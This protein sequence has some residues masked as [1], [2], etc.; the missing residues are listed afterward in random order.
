MEKKIQDN[1]YSYKF[2]SQI[3][4]IKIYLPDF[5]FRKDEKNKGVY[6]TFIGR[7]L[8]CQKLRNWLTSDTKT[9][10]YLVTGYRG[11]G[12]TSV[13]NRVID[14]ITRAP[15]RNTEKAFYV[16]II[17]L[18][19]SFLFLFEFT[20]NHFDVWFFSFTSLLISFC[21]LLF[22]LYKKEVNRIIF[23]Q[24]IKKY[25]KRYLY[26]SKEIISKLRIKDK[27]DRQ[28][29]RLKI[30]INLG[31][32][33]LNE[34]DILCLIAC[35]IRDEYKDFVKIKQSTPLVSY[36]SLFIVCVISWLA[37][38][39]FVDIFSSL[40]RSL[41]DI[42]QIY[43]E[44]TESELSFF[45]YLM[46]VINNWMLS[47]YNKGWGS[48]F[49]SI[50]AFTMTFVIINAFRLFLY[51]H[52]IFFSKPF[53]IINRLDGLYERISASVN[54]DNNQRGWSNGI[55]NIS[56]FRHRN[57][58]YPIAN[59]REIE[60]ELID[61]IRIIN[62]NGP[63][64]S[65]THFIIVFD[66]LDK[67]DTDNKDEKDSKKDDDDN[68]MEFK[69]AVSGFP[70]GMASR[71]RRQNVLKLLAN[72][73]LFIS[74][75]QAKFVFISGREL[76]DASLADLSDREFAISSI[77]N[78]II[79]V[80]SFLSPERGET[81]I[82]SMTEQYI[83]KMLLPADYLKDKIYN[84]APDD[85]ALKE[86]IPS[87]RW[88]FEYLVKIHITENQDINKNEKNMLNDIEHTLL[89]LHYFSV[90]LSQISNGSPKK[91]A[92]FFEKYVKTEFDTLRPE[93]WDDEIVF[94]KPLENDANKRQCVLF[95]D[96]NS[97]KKINFI[98]HISAPIMSTIINNASHYGDKLLVSASFMIDHIYKH[99]NGGFSWR[100]LEQ[101]PEFFDTGKTPELRDFMN[102]IMEFLLQ[103][104]IT[105]IL[106]GLYQF[107]FQKSIAEEISYISKVSDEASAIF[108]FTLDESLSM[109]E[110][111]TKLLNHHLGLVSKW[112]G[113]KNVYH[114]VI[115]RIYSNLADLYLM[116][117][118]YYYAIINYRNA[119]KNLEEDS[120]DTVANLLTK[121]RYTLKL[122]LSYEY[123]RT[124]DSAYVTYNRLVNKLINIRFIKE[125]DLGLD[126]IDKR[127]YDWRNKIPMLIDTGARSKCRD[128]LS[129]NNNLEKKYKNQFNIGIWNKEKDI[130]PAEYSLDFDELISG[131]SR[132]LTP[133]KSDMILKLSFFEEV[134]VI[135]QVILAK[136]FVLEKMDLT[137]I[138]QTSINIAESEFRFLH[139]SVNVKEKF[140]ISADFFRKMGEILY[141]KNSL[142][143]ISSK[144]KSLYVVLFLWGLDMYE[145]L[146]DFSFKQYKSNIE[147]AVK[148][149]EC[150][151]WFFDN[152]EIDCLGWNI[153]ESINNW[154]EF[155]D[156]LIDMNNK[157]RFDNDIIMT[158]DKPIELTIEMNNSED[159]ISELKSIINDYLTYERPKYSNRKISFKKMHSCVEHRELLI[160]KGLRLPCYA[161][162][163]YYLSLNILLDNMFLKRENEKNEVYQNNDQNTSRSI[164]LLRNLSRE[165]IKCLRL[166]QMMAFASTV[167]GQGEVML[168]CASFMKPT[169]KRKEDVISKEVVK[170]LTEL[171]KDDDQNYDCIIKKYENIICADNVLITQIDKS[172]LYY[173]SAYR[174]YN[175]SNQDKESVSCLK[176]II[177]V[178]S[179]YI[180]LVDFNKDY[181]SH[182]FAGECETIGY[183]I[184][185]YDGKG[186]LGQLYRRMLILISS[187]YDHFNLAEMHQ[188]KWMFH[189]EEHEDL[190]LLKS[191]IFPDAQVAYLAIID[192]VSK[193]KSILC[194]YGKSDVIDYRD[195]IKKIYCNIAPSHRLEKTFFEE[196]MCNTYKAR[197]NKLTLKD[198]LNGDV[199]KD[200]L[201]ISKYRPDYHIKF[202]EAI[203][204]YILDKSD[205]LSISIF[206]ADIPEKRFQ[207]LAFLIQD[208][209]VCLTNVLAILTPHS[210][211][212]SFS[213][214]FI[215]ET[216]N[217]LWEWSRLYELLYDM[218][219]YKLYKNRNDNDNM[220]K[221][222]D[223]L[224]R[225]FFV[226]PMPTKQS[227][228]NTIERCL[229][230]VRDDESLINRYGRLKSR[231]FM[232]LRHNVDDATIHQFISNYSAEM[233]IK[234]YR[235]IKEIHTEGL[236]YKNMIN[237]F[238]LL[239][240][241]LHNDTCQFN[242]ASERYY[243]NSGYHET[244][245]DRLEKLYKNSGVF[246]IKNYMEP[247]DFYTCQNDFDGR[248]ED[249]LY[250]NSEY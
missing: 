162:R 71:E 110:H 153:L 65:R 19:F 169:S 156:L 27:R 29:K 188:Y 231:I 116:D 206:K 130:K 44:H 45:I 244:K 37:S 199:M 34:R 147:D 194:F 39:A 9:G 210:H 2:S 40:S 12:K 212:T 184:N 82:C 129:G 131:L 185:D 1:P 158:K 73:K 200:D 58:V 57:K 203:Y 74:T 223:S 26:Y 149:K 81:D 18:F 213:N 11:M 127:T 167:E 136:L 48:L 102:S 89:F 47:I 3:K 115:S 220:Q 13:V 190:S 219:L 124:Y 208:T 85:I 227:I 106:V 202:Y 4:S 152:I 217:E 78:G 123:S 138:T 28:Y 79:N 178:I 72:M 166:N 218:Y 207:L 128:K 250:T 191:S 16:S 242:L 96:K 183:I 222:I 151:K 86:E 245:N 60:S 193:A 93:G 148:V 94:G 95:F 211:I 224:H 233:A 226:E 25:R 17:L 237:D 132:D 63:N 174:L 118:E 246:R 175:F 77:F 92:M 180:N 248:F 186:L 198:I 141:Y 23:H 99:H 98:F 33:V 69:S 68:L 209:I 170:L 111:Y 24:E 182:L 195:F 103:T 235:I 64:W 75:A 36:I 139:R 125:Q 22:A 5:K 88:Y 163:Y 205:N 20:H 107:K 35:R 236:A 15:E 8:I 101:M 161:C 56:L 62:E 157:N 159:E 55:I 243:L 21:L 160:K 121:I 109:K 215:A 53:K 52:L 155:V 83:S 240:D 14:D 6:D 112:K 7:D 10:S 165:K 87:L 249:S 122:G 59:M 32:E 168:S 117:E 50:M 142:T 104:H 61:I 143:V 234:Y 49:F 91:I 146:D 120:P 247:K 100:N 135:Y 46:T 145:D 189:K 41:S 67:I 225:S 38:S 221:I 70:D 54:E 42:F 51:K 181:N 179:C 187:K 232:K 201:D 105:N 97:Q 192:I 239:D 140:M 197:F 133:T 66:E 137:G 134:R 228:K 80:D 84:T 204:D 196:I 108:N 173:W 230:Y 31:H 90:Y 126:V 150:I 241:D 238:F 30:N 76:F 171:S 119:L 114:E 164:I 229:P 176:K 154:E 144:G 172:L 216:Y 177:Q 43:Q 113:D 214:G